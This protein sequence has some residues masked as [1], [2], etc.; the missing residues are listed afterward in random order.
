MSDGLVGIVLYSRAFKQANSRNRTHIKPHPVLLRTEF[1]D[2]NSKL[3]NKYLE[4]VNEIVWLVLK[5]G[6]NFHAR[7]AD[8]TGTVSVLR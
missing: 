4:L 5:S 8:C 7:L 1:L 3:N 6:F 2:T